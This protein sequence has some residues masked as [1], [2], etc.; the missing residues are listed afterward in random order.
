MHM[1]MAM[2]LSLAPLSPLGPDAGRSNDTALELTSDGSPPTSGSEEKCWSRTELT[3][4][5]A[6]DAA[7]R[8]DEGKKDPWDE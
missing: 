8:Y 3:L 7:Q 2:P 6:A 4:R 1:T 5:D